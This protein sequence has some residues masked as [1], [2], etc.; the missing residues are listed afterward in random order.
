MPLLST[1]NLEILILALNQKITLHI[2]M[3]YT[4]TTDNIFIFYK[5]KN[6]CSWYFIQKYAYFKIKV[7][8]RVVYYK[9]EENGRPD[10]LNIAALTFYLQNSSQVRNRDEKGKSSKKQCK[11]STS[12]EKK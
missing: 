7:K 10:Y 12:R 2:I 11:N 9:E 1:I 5:C 4:N 6:K 8:Y 3:T